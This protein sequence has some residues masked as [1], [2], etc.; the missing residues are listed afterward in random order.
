MGTRRNLRL[1]GKLLAVLVGFAPTV[2]GQSAQSSVAATETAPESSVTDSGPYKIGT[3]ELDELELE[4]TIRQRLLRSWQYAYQLQ[5]QPAVLVASSG[6]TTETI[7]NPNKWL[8]EHEIVLQLSEW[9]PRSTNLPALIQAAYDE[10][11]PSHTHSVELGRD[12][13]GRHTAVLE[14]LASQGSWWGRMFSGA[15]LNF[16]VSQR[17]EVQQGVLVPTL[18]AS[19]SWTWG[20]EVDFNP[21][22]LFLTSTNWTKAL[23]VLAVDPGEKQTKRQM[24]VQ[25]DPKASTKPSPYDSDLCIQKNL[26]HPTSPQPDLDKDFASCVKKFTQARLDSSLSHSGWADFAAVAIPTFQLKVFRSY[27]INTFKRLRDCE[28]WETE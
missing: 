22:S 25:K 11:D 24:S 23:A 17:D 3:A 16:S 28:L 5:E 13:C 7:P 21:S 10:R 6:G 26:A 15:T 20:G 1:L 2:F 18:T 9:F 12:L 19:E 27:L 8:Q 4:P 14:C